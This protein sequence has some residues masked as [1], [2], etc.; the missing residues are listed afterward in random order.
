MHGTHYMYPC[1]QVKVTPWWC[2]IRAVDVEGACGALR[3]CDTL[4]E[5]GVPATIRQE[6]GIT[7]ALGLTKQ[8][9]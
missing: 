8:V 4:V 9:E 2:D 3:R 1:V 5:G 6:P 7:K